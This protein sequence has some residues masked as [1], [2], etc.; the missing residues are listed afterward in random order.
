MEENL[1]N[2]NLDSFFR[3]EFENLPDAPAPDGWDIPS[4]DLWG[5]IEAA[6]PVGRGIFS[7]S[8]T[9]LLLG[10]LLLGMLGS[11]LFLWFQ[12]RALNED[13]RLQAQEIELLNQASQKDNITPETIGAISDKTEESPE[14]HTD[15]PQESSFTKQISP[16]SAA[17][18]KKEDLS[19]FPVTEKTNKRINKMAKTPDQ[20]IFSASAQN[21]KNDMAGIDL[22]ESGKT[23]RIFKKRKN[24]EAVD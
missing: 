21:G 15:I 17:P 2:D 8:R 10:I 18:L 11:T 1:H 6:T 9:K 5:R 4:D 20:T 13:I 19:A 7:F 22:P 23:M 24:L 14:D 3:K 12:N 16:S